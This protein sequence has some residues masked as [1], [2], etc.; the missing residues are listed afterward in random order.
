MLALEKNYGINMM[1]KNEKNITM[2]ISL[3]GAIG[4]IAGVWGA[5][6]AHDASKFKQ[7][8]D[9][10]TVMVRSFQEQIQSAE[11]R[12]DNP[13]VIRVRVLYETFE[14]DWRSS[15]KL[16][17]LVAPISALVVNEVPSEARSGIN[18]ILLSLSSKEQ[19]LLVNPKTL[20]GAYF[21]VGDYQKA[22]EQYSMASFNSPE[23]V[24]TSV[25]KAASFSRLSE[26]IADAKEKEILESN[27]YDAW[28]KILEK[29]P[30]DPNI[31][32]FYEGETR[33][34]EIVAERANK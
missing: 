2:L 29:N 21:A 17:S 25:L 3:I 32:W 26:N 6:T 13:E 27:A 15:N 23:D 28:I 5:Y 18:E 30:E 11:K 12:K 33:L 7:P 10:H 8:L 24:N 1:T 22:I 9:L 14:E 34:K 20:G 16:T 31:E 19:V 4:G